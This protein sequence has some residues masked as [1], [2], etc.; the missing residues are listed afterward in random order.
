MLG[1]YSGVPV[2]NSLL[3]IVVLRIRVAAVAASMSRGGSLLPRD[4]TRVCFAYFFW[5]VDFIYGPRIQFF[6]GVVILVSHH[7]KLEM[8]IW[9]IA[10]AIPVSSTPC[11]MRCNYCCR[12]DLSRMETRS[13]SRMLSQGDVKGM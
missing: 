9:G 4:D 7:E 13:D 6:C 2:S 3:L 12:W 8:F 10:E 5:L 1:T 11:L